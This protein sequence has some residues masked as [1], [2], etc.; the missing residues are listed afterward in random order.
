MRAGEWIGRAHR[1]VDRLVGDDL[2]RQT[3]GHLIG[4]DGHYRDIEL[5]G[6]DVLDEGIGTVSAQGDFDVR[7]VGVKVGQQPRNVDAVGRDRADADRTA[8]QLAEIIDGD[9]H[10]G[11]GCQRGLRVRQHRRAGRGQPHDA[12]CPVEKGM[13][14]FAF[15]PLDLSADRRLRDVYP[16]G[17]AG[18]V[19]L[20]RDGDKVFQLPKFHK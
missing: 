7:M 5:S 17:G 2:H 9:V 14:Q 15:Q 18:E 8:H 19:G 20:L 6:A 3:P 12:A 11:D 13:A 4:P 1:G 10:V 16:L